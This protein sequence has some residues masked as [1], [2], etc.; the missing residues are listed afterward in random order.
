MDVLSVEKNNFC[1]HPHCHSLKPNPPFFQRGAQRLA[2]KGLDLMMRLAANRESVEHTFVSLSRRLSGLKIKHQKIGNIIWPYLEGGTGEHVV[3][4]HG[5]GANKDRFGVL[6]PS[7]RRFFHVVIPD[8]PGFGDHLPDWSTDY[9]IDGQVRRFKRF[10]DAAGLGEFHLMGISLGGYIA[11]CY[12]ARHPQR[13]KSLCLMDSAGFSSPVTSDALRLY[14]GRSRNIFLPSSGQQM[15]DMIDYLM[16]RPMLLPATLR[17]YWVQQVLDQL[18]WRQKLLADLLDNSLE[19][20]D[21]LAGDIKAPTLVVWGAE[22]RICHVST[23]G[24][25][26]D[27]ID[28]CRAYI[29]HGCGHIPI[30]EFP[31][32]VQKIYVDFLRQIS[33]APEA[34]I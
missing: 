32:L 2:L 1:E 17:R 24:N 15:Q 21:G 14:H 8:L 31:G 18:P 33:E 28:D 10:I 9:G 4:L 23:V 22:D 26:M 16:H 27:L 5:F 20:M 11:G 12:A 30:V 7:L 25:I 19:L 13:V 29:I 3:L 6:G 34:S